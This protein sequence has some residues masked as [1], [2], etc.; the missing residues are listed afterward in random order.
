MLGILLLTWV[1]IKNGRLF[2]KKYVPLKI[3]PYSF[4]LNRLIMK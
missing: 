2:F 3:I 1:V 4:I